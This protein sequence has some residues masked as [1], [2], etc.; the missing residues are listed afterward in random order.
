M[1]TK[2][3][4]QP[5]LDVLLERGISLRQA[6]MDMGVPWLHLRHA[7]FGYVTPKYEVRDEITDYLDLPLYSLF[8]SE[9]LHAKPLYGPKGEAQ[10]RAA[11]EARLVR[12]LNDGKQ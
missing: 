10:M 11:R 12:R 9:A 5:F 8:T 3:G 7:A 2:F 6:S 4:R 1:A